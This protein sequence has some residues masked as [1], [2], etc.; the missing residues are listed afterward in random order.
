[1][2]AKYFVSHWREM[3]EQTASFHVGRIVAMKDRM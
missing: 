3:K 2:E 1:V